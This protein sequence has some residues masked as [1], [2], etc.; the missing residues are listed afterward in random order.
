M[1]RLL[2][3]VRHV[4]LGGTLMKCRIGTLGTLAMA[5]VVCQGLLA[6]TSL[7]EQ[8]S[9]TLAELQGTKGDWCP[10]ETTTYTTC[11]ATTTSCTPC[12]HPAGQC[13]TYI[14]A[15]GGNIGTCSGDGMMNCSCGP[16]LCYSIYYCTQGAALYHRGCTSTGCVAFPLT[17]CHPCS[18]GALML[19][20]EETSCECF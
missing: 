14:V 6:T 5:F 15:A 19:K 4:Y 12:V 10:C 17:Y 2:S 11:G 3:S 7:A 1:R 8:R 13:G 20:Y 18:P 16:E 9:L